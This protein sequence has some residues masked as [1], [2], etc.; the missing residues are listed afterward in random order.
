MPTITELNKETGAGL[1]FDFPTGWIPVKYDQEENP[2]AN[3]KA[4]FY[5]RVVLGEEGERKSEEEEKSK[6][7][8]GVRAMDIVCALPG[9]GR[10]VQFIEVKDDREEKRE[11]GVRHSQLYETV[12]LKTIGTLAGLL[13]AE[14]LGEETLQGVASLSRQPQIEIILFLVEA[15]EAPQ[16]EIGSKRTLRRVVKKQL[17]S[18]LDQ[19][20]TAKLEQWGLPFTL[21]NLT[22]RRPL[23]WQVREIPANL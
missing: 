15:A 14:R 9:P 22:D 6:V 8:Q 5:R 13:L 2:G 7:A 20:L 23:E 11:R 3:E 18:T 17:K 16:L 12:L 4:G 1:V 10:R 19:R 21:Y